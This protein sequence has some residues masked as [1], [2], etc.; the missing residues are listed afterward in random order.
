[1]LEQATDNKQGSAILLRLR[2][3]IRVKCVHHSDLYNR[4]F[5]K[6]AEGI[7]RTKRITCSWVGDLSSYD[8]HVQKH[9]PVEPCI[10]PTGAAVLA[11]QATVKKAASPKKTA[12][13]SIDSDEYELR[14]AKFDYMPNGTDKAQISLKANDIVKIFELN[15]SGWAAG[16]RVDRSTREEVGEAGWFPAAY[17]EE[18]V[19]S[20]AAAAEKGA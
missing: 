11:S 9:C 2:N 20:F 19:F 5:G 7:A 15:S 13:E 10:R 18:A 17:L 4:S 1:M 8:D 16:V 3:N 6:D 14:V 12:S